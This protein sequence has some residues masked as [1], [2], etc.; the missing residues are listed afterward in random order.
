MS[1]FLQYFTE[2][3]DIVCAIDNKNQYELFHITF[4]LI[5]NYVKHNGPAVFICPKEIMEKQ[6]NF[7]LR[8]DPAWLRL[9]QLAEVENVQDVFQFLL[10]DFE[11][12][13]PKIILFG[14]EKLIWDQSPKSQRSYINQLFAM[15]CQMLK[16]QGCWWFFNT[17]YSNMLVKHDQIANFAQRFHFDSCVNFMQC[18]AIEAERVINIDRVEVKEGNLVTGNS[19]TLAYYTSTTNES[20]LYLGTVVD[21][22]KH[23][24]EFFFGAADA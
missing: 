20:G 17:S 12:M 22:L 3:R 4:I 6:T 21:T 24:R 2:K 11:S 19:K 7:I 1:D 14:F 23:A 10:K 15:K 18:E 9:V 13:N 16:N 5:L 8:S